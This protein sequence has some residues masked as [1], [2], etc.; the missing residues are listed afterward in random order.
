VGSN[1]TQGM[2]VCLCL[3]CVCVMLGSCDGLI[4]DPFTNP[5]PVCNHTHSKIPDSMI[6]WY[7]HHSSG[8]GKGPAAGSYEHGNETSRSIQFWKDVMTISTAYFLT[9]CC[10]SDEM[11]NHGSGEVYGTRRGADK[12][13]QTDIR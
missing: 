1:P 12:Y 3:F 8:S 11:K 5:Y 4:P 9:K 13:I 6:G 2:D 7:G 10:P